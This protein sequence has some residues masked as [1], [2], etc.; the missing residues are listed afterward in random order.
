MA[1]S[2]SQGPPRG[3]PR[4][5]RWPHAGTSQELLGGSCLP[6][7]AG[8][9]Q[10]AP[11]CLFLG[12]N[13]ENLAGA[14]G[15]YINGGTLEPS[16]RQPPAR[17]SPGPP[18]NSRAPPG[19]LRGSQGAS[20]VAPSGSQGPP[21]GLPGAPRR[22][23]EPPRSSWVAPRGLPGASQELLGGSHAPPRSRRSLPGCSQVL[24]L[25]V[26]LI[27]KTSPK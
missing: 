22:P 20:Q 13:K 9:S 18:G 3:L 25:R 12:L 16:A 26:I 2:G 21:R 24:I 11:K 14:H 17:T 8:S 1:P 19:A 5:P 10:V 4:A 23:Q 15:I 6:G 7:A 27:S